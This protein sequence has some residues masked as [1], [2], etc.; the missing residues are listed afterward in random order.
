V[1]AAIG[2]SSWRLVR[3]TL[4]ESTLLALMGGAVGLTIAWLTLGTFVQLSP[5]TIAG[6]D[7]I[8]IDL[9]VIAFAMG[10][11]LVTGIIFGMIPALHVRRVDVNSVLT[12]AAARMSGGR[13][14]G[15]LR[16]ALVVVELAT[17]LM[18]VT[19]AGLLMKSFARVTSID[20]GIDPSR[21]VVTDVNLSR[22]RYPD[23]AAVQA[24]YRRFIDGIAG[25]PGVDAVSVA[26]APPL[27][28]TRMSRTINE[29]GREGPRVDISG[30]D[31]G[32][33]RTSGV[34]LV[35][36]RAFNATDVPGSEPVVILN[37]TAARLVGKG[38]PVLGERFSVVDT[39]PSRVIGIAQDV[40]QRGVEDAAPAMVYVPLAQFGGPS[41]YMT[42]LARTTGD[43]TSAIPAIRDVLRR[44]DPLQPLPELETL[45]HMMSEAVAPR[46]FTFA[47]LTVFA[48][49][50]A[51]LAMIG[52]YGVMSYLVAE[53]TNEIGVRVALGA[54]SR[55]IMG[56][57]IG[58]GLLLVIAGIAFGLAGSLAAVRLLRSMLFEVSVYDP[59]IFAAGAGL[60]VV[61]ALVACAVPAR[62]AAAL[63]PVEALRA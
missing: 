22:G 35:G 44:I 36:G 17:A 2:A 13:H 20:P 24:F 59:T 30:V 4:C 61:T 19:G 41:H 9:S 18:L 58:E 34:R 26:D 42:V 53:R 57:V 23:E 46:R 47:L 38:K 48:S 5:P 54:D 33:F 62:R 32:Y 49:L 15:F 63:D 10:I 11:A 12:H 7:G 14:Q 1:R 29:N 60:L 28:G 6:A 55:R 25:I 8:S 31:S 52:L 37:E 56:F 50:G 45:E 39:A 16:R 27:G 51:I 3:F 21:I 43:P 40:R